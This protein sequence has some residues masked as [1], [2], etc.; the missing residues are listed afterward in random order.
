MV[1]KGPKPKLSLY[2]IFQIPSDFVVESQATDIIDLLLQLI[3]HPNGVHR[4]CRHRKSRGAVL[5]TSEVQWATTKFDGVCLRSLWSNSNERSE[6]CQCLVADARYMLEIVDSFK[7]AMF[8][9]ILGNGLRLDRSDAL[10]GCELCLIGGV[11]IE[12]SSLARHRTHPRL[13][14][15]YG[16][17]GLAGY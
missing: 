14:L 3:G 6:R 8:F 4:S 12:Q 15:L 10:Q 7:W 11:N 9:A 17:P 16:C 1:K 13:A 2:K 5:S